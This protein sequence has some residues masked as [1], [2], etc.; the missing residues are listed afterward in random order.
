DGA[1]EYFGKVAARLDDLM[2]LVPARLAGVA[3]VLAAVVTADS[4]G[5][6]R[7][8]ARDRARTE[9][10][11][12]GWTMAAMA[13]ALGVMLE[14]PGVYRLGSGPLPGSDDIDGSIRVMVAAAALVITVSM[15]V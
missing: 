4:V 15:L 9:S 6:L 14:K 8:L 1:L 10:P 11:N 2:N 5:A 3:I 7:A 13:G 12:A